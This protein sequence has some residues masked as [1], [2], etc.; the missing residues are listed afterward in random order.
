MI[1]TRVAQIAIV[2]T[3]FYERSIEVFL[4]VF[5]SESGN[6][7][8]NIEKCPFLVFFEATD[9]NFME[10]YNVTPS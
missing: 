4:V 2:A 8:T 5:T 9:G 6:V 10:K 3:G 7:L 1:F